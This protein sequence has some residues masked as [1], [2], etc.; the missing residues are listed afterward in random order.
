LVSRNW[1]AEG[2][3]Q[4]SHRLLYAAHSLRQSAPALGDPGLCLLKP[5]RRRGGLCLRPA[6]IG[7]RNGGFLFLGGKTLGNDGGLLLLG[8]NTRSPGRRYLLSLGGCFGGARLRRCNASGV[9]GYAGECLR[10]SSAT[11]QRALLCSL[12]IG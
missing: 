1:I 12:E 8:R 9:G 10:H 11:A 6:C 3:A 4:A 5:K 2:N 7:E